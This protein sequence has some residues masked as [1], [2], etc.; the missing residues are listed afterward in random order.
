LGSEPSWRFFRRPYPHRYGTGAAGIALNRA[1]VQRG[2]IAMPKQNDLEGAQDQGGK[3]G[4]Q[5]GMP[6][7][8]PRP[9]HGP[10]QGIVRD[11]MDQEQPRD[12]QRAQQVRRT[13]K[14]RQ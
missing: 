2:S 8:E 3:H 12:K 9:P 11:E 5:K 14:V 1:T 10:D 7:P 6:A 13:K 4:G